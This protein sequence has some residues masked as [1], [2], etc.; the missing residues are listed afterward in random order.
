MDDRKTFSTY[1]KAAEAI[2]TVNNKLEGMAATFACAQE[3]LH[4][5]GVKDHGR[6]VTLENLI[7]YMRQ[8]LITTQSIQA[9]II[10]TLENPDIS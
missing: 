5:T 10:R 1:E 3:Y 8:E 4:N 6:R 7:S 2:V 9:A